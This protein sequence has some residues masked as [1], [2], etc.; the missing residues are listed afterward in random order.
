MPVSDS[1]DGMMLTEVLVALAILSLL[2]ISMFR[3]FAQ[4]SS[5]VSRV[6]ETRQRLEIARNLLVT[7]Q[8]QPVTGPSMLG[9]SEGVRW[10]M[11]FQPAEASAATKAIAVRIVVGDLQAPPVLTSVIVKGAP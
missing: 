1:E 5:A 2:S 9:E 11:D 10:R 3:V 8:S 4:T 6:E 7:A